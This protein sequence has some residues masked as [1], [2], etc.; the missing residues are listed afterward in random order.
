MN[1]LPMDSQSRAWPEEIIVEPTRLSVGLWGESEGDIAAA[2]CAD[3]L[4][5]AKIFIHEGQLF[6]NA[7][8]SVGTVQESVDGY[9]LIPAKEYRGP[10]P[11]PYTYEGKP[12]RY[13]GQD[14]RLGRKVL[15]VCRERTAEEWADLLRRQY[16]YG[17]YFARGTYAE[18]LAEFRESSFLSANK[19]AA[20][21][22]E[23]NRADMPTTQEEMLASISQKV[24]HAPVAQMELSF[25]L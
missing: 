15:F 10:E 3:T 19:R 17:G 8:Q 1:A 5:K 18:M 12:A 20:I 24:A 13:K 11:R 2:Y 6:T 25:G 14:F 23:S 9:P 21:E 16:A 4:P 7:G 22:A